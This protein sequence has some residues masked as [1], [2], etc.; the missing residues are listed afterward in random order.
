MKAKIICPICKKK[1]ETDCEGCIAG[2]TLVHFHKGKDE[3]D[4]MEVKW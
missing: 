2:G 4:I 1:V 3:P